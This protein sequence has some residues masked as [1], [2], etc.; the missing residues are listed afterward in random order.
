MDDGWNIQQIID[1]EWAHTLPLQMQRAPFWL[2]SRAVDQFYDDDAVAEY[3][4]V[5]EEYF[6]IY[7]EEEERR[8]S[9]TIQVSTQRE[10]GRRG[11]FW[12]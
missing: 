12:Y 2:T 9:S 5:L 7:Q 4:A 1:L 8:N 3:D 11:S 10:M 6:C